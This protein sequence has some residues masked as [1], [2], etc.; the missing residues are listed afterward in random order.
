M[1][2]TV[3]NIS[4]FS[5]EKYKYLTFLMAEEF[6]FSDVCFSASSSENKWN[7]LNTI[8]IANEISH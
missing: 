6:I 1:E 4:H 2:K 8:S 3:S 7:E 5:T